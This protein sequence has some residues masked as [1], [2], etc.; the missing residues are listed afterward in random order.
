MSFF[1]PQNSIQ[2]LVEEVGECEDSLRLTMIGENEDE[3]EEEQTESMER[4]ENG[5]SN[6]RRGLHKLNKSIYKERDVDKVLKF[7]KQK[8]KRNQPREL[9]YF[10]TSACE[11]TK[12][13]PRR[14]QLKVKQEVMKAILNAEMECLDSETSRHLL[15]V[16]HL[17]LL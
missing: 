17:H 2:Y 1:L 4:S 13:L 8:Q 14:L 9:D 7:M 11:S 3:E 15:Q 6:S 16:L 5:A 12:R 10:F